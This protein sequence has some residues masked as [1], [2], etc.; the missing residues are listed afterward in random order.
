MRQLFDMATDNKGEIMSIW[1]LMGQIFREWYRVYVQW[2][3]YWIPG[4]ASLYSV[5]VISWIYNDQYQYPHNWWRMLPNEALMREEEIS[6][7][8]LIHYH[9]VQS[10][11]SR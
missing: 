9:Y 6:K 2:K 7:L 11:I 3:G 10:P 4:L 5:H 1:Q 8:S